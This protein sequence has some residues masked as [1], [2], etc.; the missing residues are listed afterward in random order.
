M[1]FFKVAA[2]YAELIKLGH[3]LFALPFALSALCLA[4]LCGHSFG[5]SKIIWTILAFAGARAAAMGFNRIVDIDIDAKNPR[6]MSR[7]SVSGK[8]SLRDSKIFTCASIILFFISA[9]MIN[10]LCFVLAFPALAVL[11]GYSYAKRFTFTAHYIVGVALALA[12]IGAWIAAADSLDPRILAFAAALLFNIAAFDLIY[13]LQDMDFDKTEGLHSIPAKFG[14]SATLAIASISFALATSFMILTGI[15]FEL[16][17]IY[18]AGVAVI[19]ILYA[20][21]EISICVWGESKTQL[22]FFYENVS[23]S[24]LIFLSITSNLL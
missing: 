21:G 16:N 7:P 15:L 5:V 1:N 17:A 2:T 19:A 18:F 20:L 22:V 8:I 24:F 11:L 14:R 9:A 6:T 3:T 4:H 10:W 13:A 12:P 23:I